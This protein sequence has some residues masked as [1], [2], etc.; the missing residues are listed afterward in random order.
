MPWPR[1]KVLGG[2]SILNYMLYIRGN[3]RDYDKWAKNGAYGWSWN[4]VFPYFLK[5]EDNTDPEMSFNGKRKIFANQ[6]SNS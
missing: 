3:K 6:V 5:S 1:G 2:S 4:E